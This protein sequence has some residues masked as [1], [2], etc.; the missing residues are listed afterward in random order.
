M[1]PILDMSTAGGRSTAPPGDRSSPSGVETSLEPGEDKLGRERRRAATGTLPRVFYVDGS[2]DTSRE[3]SQW[4]AQGIAV[5]RLQGNERTPITVQSRMFIVR[6][7]GAEIAEYA[8]VF[9]GLRV[10]Q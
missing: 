3:E 8:A 5:V 4:R 1:H 9:E 7:D 6:H 2:A 10:I